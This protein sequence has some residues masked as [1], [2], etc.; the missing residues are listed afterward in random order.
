MTHETS[1]KLRKMI[2]HQM[3]A[4]VDYRDFTVLPHALDEF[5][6]WFATWRD[7]ATRA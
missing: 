6:T 3:R 2:N 5:P 4:V 1:L 7:A